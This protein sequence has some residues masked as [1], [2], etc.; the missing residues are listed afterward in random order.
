M[1]IRSAV[2]GISR[3]VIATLRLTVAR[4]RVAGEQQM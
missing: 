1:V 3:T 2:P 4:P